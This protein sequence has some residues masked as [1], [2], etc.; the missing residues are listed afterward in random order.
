MIILNRSLSVLLILSLATVSGFSQNVKTEKKT[1]PEVTKEEPRPDGL[2]KITTHSLRDRDFDI[3][4]DHEALARNIEMAVE[5]AMKSVEGT[6]ERLEINIDPIEINLK[7]LNVDIDPIVVN[8]P[9][10]NIDIEPIEVDIPDLDID[11]DMDHHHFDWDEDN[12]ND[13]DNDIYNDDD[14]DND[15]HKAFH[16]DKVKDKSEKK[17]KSDKDDKSKGLKKL[18]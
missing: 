2:K 12:D 17:D 7:D 11:V 16:K 9:N 10:L 8:I 3:H 1:Q 15:H 14:D 6:L 13:K 4:I 5:H 18:N